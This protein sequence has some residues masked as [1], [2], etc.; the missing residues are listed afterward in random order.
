MITTKGNQKSNKNIKNKKFRTQVTLTKAKDALPLRDPY[1]KTESK[2]I[3]LSKK[4]LRQC[5]Y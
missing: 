5:L 1:K 4:I 2:T 3:A